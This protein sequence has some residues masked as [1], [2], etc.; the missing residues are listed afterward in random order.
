VERIT[1][2]PRLDIRDLQVVIAIASAGSTSSA[3]KGLAL[4]QS[5]VSRALAL[6]EG[7][8]GVA[9]FERTPRGLVPSAAGR[10]LVAGA[11][12]V[13]AQL[14]ELESI[15]RTDHPPL[16]VR[17]AAECYTAYRWLPSVVASLRERLPGI[18]V[19][20]Q[21]ERAL[22]PVAALRRGELDIALLTTAAIKHPLLER[23]L[24][25]DELVFV[26]SAHHPLASRPHITRADLIAHP[27]VTSTATPPA[28]KKQ[29]LAAAF[30]RKVP[31]LQVIQLPITEAILDVTRAG[32]G[33]AAMS[34][35]IAS[36]HV[37]TDLVIKRLASGPLYRPWRIAY[38][39]ESTEA[40]RI[41]GEALAANAPRVY[42]GRRAR[43]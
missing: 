2:A 21:L 10:R 30:G 1:N 20:L 15:A 6:A 18:E 4:T 13:L 32:V 23:A 37:G 43:A 42:A 12:A 41:I 14:A 9:L 35:W 3:A 11:G 36:A 7:K 24:M 33:I 16:H 40:A 34:E 19:E 5:A 31:R 28:E 17:L 22:D 26:M 25:D 27:L 38:R 29:F 8:L 39:P